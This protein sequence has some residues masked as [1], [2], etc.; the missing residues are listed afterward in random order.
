MTTMRKPT[1]RGVI[2]QFVIALALV[3]FAAGFWTAA[4]LEGRI[5]EAHRQLA[6][7]RSGGGRDYGGIEQSMTYIGRLPYAG[8][9]MMADIRVHRALAQY[10][11]GDFAAL[12]PQGDLSTVKEKDPEVLLLAANAAYRVGQQEGGD[13][14]AVLRRLDNAIK[15]YIDVLKISPGQ[16]DAA[17][18]YEYLAHVRTA[19]ASG[20]P[21]KGDGRGDRE[22]ESTTATDL[23]S[24]TTIHGR[25]GAVPK[26]SDMGQ[27]KAVVPKTPDEREGQPEAGS[28]KA[29]IRKG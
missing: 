7:L 1:M 9:R 11:R 26:G 23:P 4:E 28:G 3:I 19:L 22:A 5:V 18:N 16:V 13:K 10:W 29:K 15:N 27:F 14:Q 8:E 20:R 21:A 17:Y 6:T 25:P 24:G 12:A 2:G